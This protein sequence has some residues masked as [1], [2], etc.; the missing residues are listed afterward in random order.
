VTE[1]D[2][3]IPPGGAG[4]VSASLDTSHY[5]GP[6]TKSVSVYPRDAGAQPVV[7]QLKAEIV[8]ELDVAPT[9]TPVM[10]ITRGDPKPTELTVSAS[11]GH[12]F[13]IVALQADPSVAVTVAPPS[14]AAPAPKKKR[15]AKVIAAGESRYRVSIL[16]KP[17]LPVGQTIANVTLTTD[18]PKAERVAIRAV[19]AVV[20]AVQIVPDRLVLRGANATAP[21]HARLTK[22]TGSPVKILG[23]DSSEADVI[24]TTSAVR[25]GREYDLSFRYG[26]QPGRTLDARVTVRTDDREQPTVVVP[27]FVRP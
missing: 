8:T 11:D 10:R 4:K 7:L 19:I 6:I 22:A 24:A 16:P 3:V 27:I 25:D 26:G 13:T 14:A 1:F 23:V 9:D 17:D 15:A 12:P 21:V 20:G 18:R 5:K 2:K